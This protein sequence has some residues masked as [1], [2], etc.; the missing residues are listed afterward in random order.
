[1]Y[2][3]LTQLSQFDSFDLIDATFYDLT[4]SILPIRRRRVEYWNTHPKAPIFRSFSCGV[5]R[6]F[7]ITFYTSTSCLLENFVAI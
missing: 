2:S 5:S 7:Y 1:M 4:R 6:N 3:T